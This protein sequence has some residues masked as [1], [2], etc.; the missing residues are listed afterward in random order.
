[1][2]PVNG[3]G[4]F[5]GCPVNMFP[6]LGYDQVFVSIDPQLL[7]P[8]ETVTMATYAVD[9]DMLSGPGG[10]FPVMITGPRVIADI[11]NVEILD[12]RQAFTLSYYISRENNCFLSFGS[13]FFF[14]YLI[15]YVRSVR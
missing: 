7:L 15:T 4:L 12:H 6:A 10:A 13:F 2:R 11:S 9:Q 8:N 1:M 5:L 3:P 14:H